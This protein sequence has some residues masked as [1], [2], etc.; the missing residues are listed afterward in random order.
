MSGVFARYCVPL[1]QPVRGIR[2]AVLCAQHEEAFHMAMWNIRWA[3]GIPYAACEKFVV[4]WVSPEGHA[5][6]EMLCFLQCS[7]SC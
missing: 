1:T 2:Y 6:K 7:T 5:L 3:L 4:I